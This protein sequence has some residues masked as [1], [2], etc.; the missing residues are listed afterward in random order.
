MSNIKKLLL[1]SIAVCSTMSFSVQAIN[2][3]YAKKLE[4]SGCTQ[5]TEMQGCDINKTKE[6]NIKAGFGSVDSEK[7]KQS[8]SYLDLKGKNSISA[9]DAMIEHG[10][11]SVDY[12]ESGNT[13]YGIYFNS[14]TR[15]CAQLTIAEGKIVS[16]DD[17]QSHPKCL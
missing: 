8:A 3:E 11:K 13:Q 17:I 5:V 14:E 4:R 1:T 9:L 12:F 10:F 6:E 15:V 7:P 2:N 16:V